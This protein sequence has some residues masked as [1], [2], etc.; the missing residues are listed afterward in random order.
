MLDGEGRVPA[1]RGQTPATDG[2]TS[3]PETIMAKRTTASRSGETAESVAVDF[4]E[5][6]IGPDAEFIEPVQDL[7]A[8]TK[9]K[10]GKGD[11]VDPVA[12]AEAAMAKMAERFDG[13]MADE[14]GRL[15]ELF[16]EAQAGDFDDALIDELHRAA[17]DIKGQAATLGFPVAGRIAAGLCRLIEAKRA[18]G[19]FS[20]EL[21]R[22]HVQSVQAIIREQARD[23]TSPTALKLA[24][25]LD[26]V[27][28]DYLEQI[29]VAA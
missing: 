5:I 29:G 12:A 14:T 4:D 6:D 7:R 9:S 13:W 22:H 24:D 26:E 27:T 19:H 15:G 11:D 1:T 3:S 25:R 21:V 17:H 16:A 20:T 10:R 23:E 28:D 18:T 8:K 2:A